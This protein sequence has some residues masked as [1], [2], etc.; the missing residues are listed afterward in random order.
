MT[1]NGCDVLKGLEKMK[2]V[3]SLKIWEKT[4]TNEVIFFF[5]P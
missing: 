3:T 2:M 5:A 1:F 4:K